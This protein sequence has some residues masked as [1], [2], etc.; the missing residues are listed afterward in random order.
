M[1]IGRTITV[2]E[3]APLVLTTDPAAVDVPELHEAYDACL[4]ADTDEPMC[5][6]RSEVTA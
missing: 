1:R 5:A 3:A 2:I 6:P 4:P